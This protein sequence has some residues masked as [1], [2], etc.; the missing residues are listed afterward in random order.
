LDYW[1]QWD[2]SGESRPFCTDEHIENFWTT[3][4]EVW[5]VQV[6]TVVGFEMSEPAV[7]SVTISNTTP[8]IDTVSIF[9]TEPTVGDTLTC[10]PGGYYDDDFD[11]DNTRIVWFNGTESVGTGTEFTGTVEEGD[12]IRC[13]ATANDGLED[14][15]AL[16]V[17]VTI[18]S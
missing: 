5:Q 8:T 9:P 1:F 4:G 2:A 17:T 14:G 12:S 11:D 16:D 13:E 10:V 6:F 18:G 3:R 15:T 7:A